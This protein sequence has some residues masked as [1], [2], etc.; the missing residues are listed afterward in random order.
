[1]LSLPVCGEYYVPH[2]ESRL[3]LRSKMATRTELGDACAIHKVALA[4]TKFKMLIKIWSE[5]IQNLS[6]CNVTSGW[7]LGY[8]QLASLLRIAQPCSAQPARA[9][10]Q[11]P[12]TSLPQQA[13]L[14]VRSA[15]CDYQLIL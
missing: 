1:M 13:Q 3:E 4:T 8:P 7:V 10:R 14:S 15:L 2:R 9:P 6:K 5:R 12:G 11:L